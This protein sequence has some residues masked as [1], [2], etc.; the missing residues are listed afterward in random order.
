MTPTEPQAPHH[1][2]AEELENED[3]AHELS[4]VDVRGILAFG[5]GLVV[6]TAVAFLAMWV[7]FRVLD[8]QAAA[9]DPQVSPLAVPTGQLP[10]V[11]RLQTNEPASL[12]K[13]RAIEAEKL[14]TYGW[15]DQ[16]A[17]VARIPLD[18]AKKKLL[19]HGLPARPSAVDPSVGT[20]APAMAEPSGGR[21]IVR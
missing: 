20:R 17:G 6:V 5:A 13:F 19:E 21:S 14:E 10:P 11:P 15:I 3:V 8:A 12:L 9:N 4:D 7:L 16:K 2:S 18:E 1:Y